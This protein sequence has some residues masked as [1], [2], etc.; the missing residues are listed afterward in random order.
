MIDK[1]G[2]AYALTPKGEWEAVKATVRLQIVLAETM[3]TRERAWDG[4]WHIVLFDFPEKKRPY[5]D[6]LRLTLKRMGFNEFQRSTWISPHPILG[7][8]QELIHMPQ[9]ERHIR[10]ITAQDINYDKDLR[11]FFRLS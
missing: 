1:D 6:Y 9:L 3:P 2:Y 5:R 10:L 8:L 7:A 4:K 11:K